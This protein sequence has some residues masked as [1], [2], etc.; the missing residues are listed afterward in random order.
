LRSSITRPLTVADAALAPATD[1]ARTV[2][3]DGAVRSA[4]PSSCSSERFSIVAVTTDWWPA[5]TDAG[6]RLTL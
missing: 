1:A 3:A 6:A 4:E 2:N 5:G